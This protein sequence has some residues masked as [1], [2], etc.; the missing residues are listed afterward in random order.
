[1]ST[2]FDFFLMGIV[3]QSTSGLTGFPKDRYYVFVEY[4][5]TGPPNGPVLF[6]TLS[7][8]SVCNMRGRSAAGPGTWP[9]RRPI[10]HSG[11]VRLCPIRAT[12]RLWAKCLPVT[13]LAASSD[14]DQLK[15]LMEI[16]DESD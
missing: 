14:C 10:L 9:V 3:F 2:T 6:C 16:G 12:P 8:V 7:S 4:F 15:A 5:F 13:Q 1:M 11:T